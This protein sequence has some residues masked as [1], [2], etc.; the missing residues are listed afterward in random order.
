[1][2]RREKKIA[3]GQLVQGG[4]YLAA[5]ASQGFTPWSLHYV[6]LRGE[7]SYISF[8]ETTSLIEQGLEAASTAIEAVEQGRI[9]PN[10]SD[11]ESC[12]HCEFLTAC[13]WK[14]TEPA[15]QMEA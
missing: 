4:L 1:M 8:T 7:T 14:T 9:A 3:A 2:Q 12:R 10:P 15:R 13:R 5:L 11:E 6:G